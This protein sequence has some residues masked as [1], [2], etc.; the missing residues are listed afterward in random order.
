[1]LNFPFSWCQDRYLFSAGN[2]W[3]CDDEFCC[4]GCG[5]QEQFINCADVKIGFETGGWISP[6]ITQRPAWTPRPTTKS[7]PTKTTKTPSWWATSSTKTTRK[8]WWTPRPTTAKPTAKPTTKKVWWTPRPTTKKVLWTPQP[9]TKKVWWQPRT[10]TSRPAIWWTTP[11]GSQEKCK[12]IGKW[13]SLDYA[14]K[15]CADNCARCYC[16]TV[17]CATSC[18]QL[19]ASCPKLQIKVNYEEY[20][21]VLPSHY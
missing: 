15:W 19:G 14:D 1:M 10:T 20:G 4:I 8:V 3:G 2:S 6:P 5:P 16:P 9:T 12:A 13:S 7:P 21:P 11:S 18:F 17:S